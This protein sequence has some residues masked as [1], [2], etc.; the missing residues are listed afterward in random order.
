M[1]DDGTSLYVALVQPA[2]LVKELH[3]TFTLLVLHSKEMNEYDMVLFA[4]FIEVCLAATDP[5]TTR[6]D[7]C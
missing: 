3:S 1:D 7:C 6:F 2:L 5:R 4:P